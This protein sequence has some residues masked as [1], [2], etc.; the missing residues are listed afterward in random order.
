MAQRGKNLPAMQETWVQSPGRE[1]PLEKEMTTHSS[2]RA[3]RIPGTEEPGRPQSMGF[4]ESHTEQLTLTFT[5]SLTWALLEKSVCN[6]KFSRSPQGLPWWVQRWNV[7][8]P[9]QGTRVRS[10]ALEDSTSLRAAEST[11]HNS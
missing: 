8:L 5:F 10:L 1:D 7:C 11:C 4:A 9:M 3:W 6:L 2:I